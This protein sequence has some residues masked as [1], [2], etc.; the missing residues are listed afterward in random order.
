MANDKN[1]EGLFP[2][3]SKDFVG[4]KAKIVPGTKGLGDAPVAPK[5]EK[6]G[7]K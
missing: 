3:G 2:G 7:N 1:K 4:P 6:G 5:R